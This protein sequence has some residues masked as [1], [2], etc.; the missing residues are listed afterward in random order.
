MRF[1]YALPHHVAPMPE[2]L[3][4]GDAVA[5]LARAAEAAGF[6]A[7]AC[8]EHPA[9]SERWRRSGGHD[10]LDPYATLAYAAAVTG[11]LRLVT[12]LSPVPYR[13]PFLLAKAAT[14][15]DRLSGGRLTLGVGTGYLRSEFAALGV[16]F[17]RRNDAF[18]EAVQVLLRAWQGEPVDHDGSGFTAVGTTS[19]PRPVQRPHP[20]IWIGGNSRRSRERAASVGDGWMPMPVT[21]ELRATA[22]TAPLSGVEDLRPLVDEV[23][24]LAAAAGRGPLDIVFPVRP[25]GVDDSPAEHLAT[26]GELAAA[27]VTWAAVNGF[28]STIAEAVGWI[29]RYGADVIGQAGAVRTKEAVS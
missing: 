4:G 9:P 15:V 3:A 17:A 21:A 2:E 29:D 5:A 26:V 24:E 10:C 13:N 18:D 8:T 25:P 19:L 16:D 1:L 20:P 11:T 22:R 14:T 12:Y 28:G 6:D 23:Q 7:V 27:G